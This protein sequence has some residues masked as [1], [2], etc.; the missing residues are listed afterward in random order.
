MAAHL[1][2]AWLQVRHARQQR[3]RAKVVGTVEGVPARGAHQ[4]EAQQRGELAGRLWR[5][6]L[7]GVD[8]L[9]L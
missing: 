7:D 1:Q 5:Q 8:A 9:L 2:H 6:R 3:P 4:H